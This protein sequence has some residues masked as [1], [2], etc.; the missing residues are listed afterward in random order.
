MELRELKLST[1]LVTLLNEVSLTSVEDLLSYYP[2]RYEEVNVLPFSEWKKGEKITVE[3]SIIAPVKTVFIRKSMSVSRFMFQSDHQIYSVTIFN[4]PWISNIKTPITI[5][6]KYEGES[7]ITATSYNATPLLDQIGIHPVYALRKGLSQK[8]IRLAMQRALSVLGTMYFCDLPEKFKINYR[9]LPMKTALRMIHMPN[10]DQ[11][12]HAAS[13]T[14]KYEELLRFQTNLQLIRK[15]TADQSFGKSK[16][17]DRRVIKSWEAELPFQLTESQHEVITEI[18]DDLQSS[19]RMYRLL[20]GDVGSG[21]TVVAALAVYAC[22][23]SH[24]QA[25]L[26]A[27]TELL[28]QQ[29]LVTMREYLPDSIRIE[30]LFASLPA[31]RK[32]QILKELREGKIDFLIGTHAIIQEDV[33]FLNCGLVVAD[34]QHRFGVAQRRALSSKGDKVDFLL[35]SATPIPRTLASALFGDLDVSTI[36]NYHSGKQKIHTEL[37]R[38]NSIKPILKEILDQIK[39]GSQVYVVCPAIEEDNAAEVRNVTQ[40]A[41]SLNKILPKEVTTGVLHGKLNASDKENVLQRFYQGTI[42]VLVTTTVIEVGVNIPSANTII[43]YDSD[44]FGLSQLHQLRGRVGRGSVEGMCYLLSDS[45]DEHTLER[46]LVLVENDDGFMIA[47]K[48][49]EL[50]GPGEMLGLKQSG[51]P[52]FLIANVVRDL[53]ILET[54]QKDAIW[55]IQNPTDPSSIQWLNDIKM[56]QTDNSV[57][58]D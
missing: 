50:R 12:I 49:L 40:V 1:R 48:D 10:S 41:E 54:A 30:A 37:L 4:R 56:H 33:K 27:P 15:S 22:I 18:L 46:L 14:L 6:G 23:L 21:K 57:L 31:V 38:K 32:R 47:N 44:R 55:M 26:L 34:E 7:S 19:R 53:P 25:A 24:H 42:Q 5:F 9:L 11:E 16:I 45:D 17:F 8:D 13:R 29:H 36:R 52:S 20:Q 3:G 58:M 39:K 2:V 43:I 35:M 51:I 28:A